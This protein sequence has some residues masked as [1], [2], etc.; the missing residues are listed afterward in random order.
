MLQYKVTFAISSPHYNL[1]TLLL[2]NN[3]RASPVTAWDR[4]LG[5]AIFIP[6]PQIV[7]NRQ[8]TGIDNRHGTC[9]YVLLP[10]INDF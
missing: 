9:R 6:T 10:D 8:W 1:L 2:V 3:L 4:I 7:D 5:L